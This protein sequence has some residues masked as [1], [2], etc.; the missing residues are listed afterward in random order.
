MQMVIYKSPFSESSVMAISG[1]NTAKTFIK[2]IVEEGLYIQKNDYDKVVPMSP[3]TK[4]QEASAMNAKIC[5]ICD[6]RLDE[7]SPISQ[8]NTDLHRKAIQHYERLEN[9]GKII[10]HTEMLQISLDNL[11]KNNRMVYDHDHLTGEFRGVAHSICNL[12]I[13]FQSLSQYF[14]ITYLAMTRIY[15]SRK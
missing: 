8:R 15:S 4:E 10:F 1:E 12:T 13:N 7:T 5:H 2:N 11:E 3:L 14:S 6:S 9:A